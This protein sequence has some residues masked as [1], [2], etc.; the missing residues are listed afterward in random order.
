MTRLLTAAVFFAVAAA[1]AIACEFQKSVSTDAQKRAVA[2][3]PAGH[4]TV[5]A[6]TAGEH[7]PS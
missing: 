2:S 5:P 1:P 7:K 4:S 6:R 3:Q